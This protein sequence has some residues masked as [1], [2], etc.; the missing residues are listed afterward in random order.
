M[1]I[2]ND[3]C[4]EINRISAQ[5]LHKCS[6]SRDYLAVC[7]ILSGSKKKSSSGSELEKKSGSGSD[8][9]IRSGSGSELEKNSAPAA[10]APAPKSCL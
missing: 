10:P 7:I 6:T 2:S 8:L 5:I 3:S 1:T 9:E 4:T